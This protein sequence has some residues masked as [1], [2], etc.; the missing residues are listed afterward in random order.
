MNA[1][2]AIAL[3]LAA[4]G[5]GAAI[6]ILYS[7]YHAI[8]SQYA[9][10]LSVRGISDRVQLAQHSKL[11]SKVDALI[12][13][14][15]TSGALRS[16]RVA[17][18]VTHIKSD[19]R[20]IDQSVHHNL[21]V[22]SRVLS[23]AERTGAHLENLAVVE[24]LIQ[25]RGELQ[26]SYLEAVRDRATFRRRRSS[27][28]KNAPEWAISEFNRKID[29]LTDRIETNRRSLHTQLEALLSDAQKSSHDSVTYH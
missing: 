18:V 5:C 8:L 2:L 24:D 7:W 12:E 27:A 4:L 1:T 28:G 29:E 14:G 21:G 20:L 9:P 6:Y 19:P 16:L 23:I 10:H 3:V 17:L 13:Q 26:T 15:N 11:L 25:L 22:L